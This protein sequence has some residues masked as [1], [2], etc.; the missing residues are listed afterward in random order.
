LDADTTWIKAVEEYLIT[1]ESDWKGKIR[2]GL[3][4]DILSFVLN[5]SPRSILSELKQEGVNAWHYFFNGMS[6]HPER[7]LSY[8]GF[9]SLP[10][11]IALR[12][13]S[14]LESCWGAA[15]SFFLPEELHWL[16]KLREH[17]TMRHNGY[18]EPEP[19]FSLSDLE[20]LLV[21][22]GSQAS[23]L[24]VAV[25]S[26]ID[27]F[28]MFRHEF[29]KRFRDYHAA[30]HRNAEAIRPV[31]LSTQGNQRFRLPHI[32]KMLE[33]VPADTLALFAAEFSELG[34]S[35]SKQVAEAV[36]PLIR[37][38]SSACAESL[39]VIAVQGE[40]P[41]QRANACRLLRKL[42]RQT[43]NTELDKF[44]RDTAKADQASSVQGLAQQWD[45]CDVASEQIR[46]Q[47]HYELPSI[48]WAGTMSPELAEVLETMWKDLDA[49]I[50]KEN[51]LN[52]EILAQGGD[53]W[54]SK[55]GRVHVEGYP[56]ELHKSLHD[57]LASPEPVMADYPDTTRPLVYAWGRLLAP[58]QKL[59]TAP[60]VNIV[61]LAKTFHF[62]KIFIER[63]HI[64]DE[65]LLDDA[66]IRAINVMH[67]TTKKPTLLEL[68]QILNAMGFSGATIL[69]NS[70]C[71]S[72]GE[73]LANEWEN[74]A[75]WPFFAHNQDLLVD[76]LTAQSCGCDFDRNL[77]FK[78]ISTFPTI[79][80]QIAPVLFDIALGTSKTYRRLAQTTLVNHPDKE[81]RIIAAL[82]EGQTETRAVA[83][84]WLGRLKYSPAIPVLEKA[85]LDEKNDMAKGAMLDALQSLGQPVEKYLDRKALAAQA[86]K[87]LSKG[88]PKDLE[89]FPFAAL[90]VLRWQDSGEPVS[91]AILR[92]LIVQAVKQKT[93]EPNAIL[94]KYCTMFHPA[95]REAF[96]Q[97]VL[98]AWIS[99]DLHPITPE[100]AQK[101]AEAFV[102]EMHGVIG[103]FYEGGEDP[104][105]NRRFEKSVARHLHL[106]LN[107]PA[108][109]QIGTKGLLAVAGACAG[110]GAA[111]AVSRYLKKYYG[112]RAGQCKALLAMLSWIDHP[113][114]TH[115]VLSTGNRFRT[116]SIQAEAAK[117][118]E[119]LAERKGWSVS[120]LADRTI[121]SGGFDEN[122]ILELSFGERV[123]TA[124]LLP[125]F[126]IEL[127]GP[128]GKK[129]ASLPA[130]R[131]D[132]N[133]ELAK[134][135]KEALA[136]AK[137]EIKSVITLQKARL[138]EAMCTEHD[139]SFEDWSVCLFQ[140]PV[141]RR[142]VQGL[143]WAQ[144][145][146]G[147]VVQTFRPLNDGSLVD[148]DGNEVTMAPDA[149]IG[150]AHEMVL[151]ADMV[152]R[153]QRH[154]TGHKISPLFQQF[155][156]GG[157]ILPEDKAK[158]DCFNDFEGYLIEAFDL[159]SRALKLGYARGSAED[160]GWFCVYE[161]PFPTS[162]LTA[163]LEFSG[164]RLPEEKRTVALKTL[165]FT[166][167]ASP[168]RS[169]LVLSRIPRILLS[170][171][172]QDLRLIAAGCSGF[173]PDLEY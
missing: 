79:P 116:K 156:K 42:A 24:M 15:V 171:C 125:D 132:D 52:R 14:V 139:W 81:A 159:K 3:A 10:A 23:S 135:S 59:A 6:S 4:S 168:Q 31:I 39:K 36:E 75:V 83:A 144:V 26:P 170:E 16:E 105:L 104:G 98:D 145:I 101:R 38:C 77:L 22:A 155:G 160:G 117:L 73:R 109:S 122:G 95:D 115:L 80:P 107:E 93:P 30:V 46:Q 100:E 20:K 124:K 158:A 60:G 70:Y 27:S 28:L 118:A 8:A 76:T 2:P 157:Y 154:L 18:P 44:A 153:W 167:T 94:R 102:R 64:G 146:D 129:I 163:V 29:V 149:R 89:W 150:I 164:N 45:E 12:W 33:G 173:N 5:G 69:L 48:D 114:A 113:A 88:I 65:S 165:F 120:E 119:A 142:M 41:E 40:K 126:K 49:L 137:K 35:S 92:W 134:E 106:F 90:P 66:A 17:A 97:F 54:N 143:V 43:N 123:F 121:P 130:P 1:L 111:I 103:S 62:F 72:G 57:H 11:S 96:G 9:T 136:I 162:G 110:K 37:A 50:E 55:R 151:S 82:A 133:A 166:K 127:I 25:F 32:I 91:T 87:G 108:G 99:E 169:P 161:K 61:A 34:V 13:A 51:E 71:S 140:H 68:Q 84:Q 47:L 138:Y 63:L 112:T 56:E 67:G 152:K 85:T 141:V 128:E 74:E 147:K 7:F 53:P 58:V 131:S 19:P 21:A 86:V 172:Y 148:C 78:A